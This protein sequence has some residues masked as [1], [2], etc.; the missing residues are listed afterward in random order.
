MKAKVICFSRSSGEGL[1]RPEGGGALVLYACNIPGKKTWYPETACMYYE[2]GQE[3]EVTIDEYGFVI[4][5]TP[6]IFDKAKWD[7]LDHD[8]LAF[9]CDETDDIVTGLFYSKEED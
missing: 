9:K 2:E 3:I 8:Q 6:G 5:I 4:P 1:L 7:S